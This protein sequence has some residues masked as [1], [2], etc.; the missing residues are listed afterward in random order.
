MAHCHFM[1]IWKWNTT[2]SNQRSFAAPFSATKAYPNMMFHFQYSQVCRC[3]CDC[4]QCSHI[5]QVV[6]R[7][8]RWPA[9]H[10]CTRSHLQTVKHTASDSAASF[11]KWNKLAIPHGIND[12]LSCAWVLLCICLHCLAVQCDMLVAIEALRCQKHYIHYITSAY[13][14]LH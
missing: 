2:E 11:T 12:C 9:K 10:Q 5:V 13:I 4:R 3:R 6:E 8:R 14:T 1:C 7:I